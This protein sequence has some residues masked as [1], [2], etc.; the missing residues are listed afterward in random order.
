M[1]V[2]NAGMVE[3]RDLEAVM[4]AKR[5]CSADSSA[6]KKLLPVSVS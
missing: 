1:K 3:N 4:I 6:C 5:S 2:D